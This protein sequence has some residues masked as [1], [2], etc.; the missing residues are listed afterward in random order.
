MSLAHSLTG[1]EDFAWTFSRNTLAK[2]TACDNHQDR[3]AIAANEFSELRHYVGDRMARE[4][5]TA[6]LAWPGRPPKWLAPARR[7]MFDDIDAWGHRAMEKRGRGNPQP[8]H[9]LTNEQLDRLN[10]ARLAY[11][12]WREPNDT[13]ASIA[14]AIADDPQLGR[15]Q[16]DRNILNDLIDLRHARAVSLT[17]LNS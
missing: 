5:M 10:A 15:G 12:D 14:Q 11:S 16:D 17:A 6:V 1:H 2:L 4:I 7:A 13:H 9:Q 3:Q 8:A